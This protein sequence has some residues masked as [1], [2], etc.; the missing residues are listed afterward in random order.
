MNNIEKILARPII[1]A[2]SIE[3]S[4]ANHFKLCSG[5]SDLNAF[6]DKLVIMTRAYADVY[7]LYKLVKSWIISVE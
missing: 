6:L 7:D 2:L 1:R 3:S 5:Y 4:L